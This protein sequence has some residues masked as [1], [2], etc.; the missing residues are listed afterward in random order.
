MINQRL[1][2]L[3]KASGISQ[4]QMA[5]LLH[6]S[7]NAYSLMESGKSKI[8]ASLIPD[9]CKAFNVTPDSLFSLEI[10]APSPNDET[11]DYIKIIKLLKD[12]LDKKNEMLKLSLQ[13]LAEFDK[14]VEKIRIL[15]VS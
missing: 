12:E 10:T 8:D 5:A 4:S 2:Q 14:V 3:R 1:K 11:L 7:Q 15:S 9:I 13:A 6:K